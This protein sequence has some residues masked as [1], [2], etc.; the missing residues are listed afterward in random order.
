[1]S[2]TRFALARTRVLAVLICASALITA[3]AGCDAGP[4]TKQVLIENVHVVDPVSGL[5]ENRQ[6]LV[7]DGT[8]A[9]VAE[10]SA[11]LVFNTQVERFDGKGRYLM[12]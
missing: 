4:T 7:E 6:V 8:I 3:L 2:N 10:A 1:M 5:S 12:P 11:Q 9:A